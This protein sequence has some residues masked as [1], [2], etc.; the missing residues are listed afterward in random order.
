MDTA[1]PGAAPIF[2]L[3]NR[4]HDSDVLY[5]NPY[6]EGPAKWNAFTTQLSIA[7]QERPWASRKSLL[8]WCSSSG[9]D[10]TPGNSPRVTAVDMFAREK[11]AD[12]AF[13][14]NWTVQCEL[15]KKGA[16]PPP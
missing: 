4:Q 2:S 3:C 15:W 12:I 9:Y 11:W 5:P 14:N 10:S 8:W 16:H 13:I 6:I 7:A 1:P